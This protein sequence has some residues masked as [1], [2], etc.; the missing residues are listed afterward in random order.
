MLKPLPMLPLALVMSLLW[1]SKDLNLLNSLAVFGHKLHG[2]C[3]D[4]VGSTS[5]WSH[6]YK[7]LSCGSGIYQFKGA[8]LFKQL[9]IIHLFVL[10]GAHIVFAERV[11]YRFSKD[12]RKIFIGLIVLTLVT[13]IKAPAFR[14]LTHW[15]LKNLSIKNELNWSPSLSIAMTGFFCLCLNPTWWLGLS[16]PLSWVATLSFCFYPNSQSKSIV[17]VYLLSLPLLLNLGP[18]SPI[19]ILVN[20]LFS[21]IFFSLLFPL[22]WLSG[23]VPALQYFCDPLWEFSLNLLSSINAPVHFSLTPYKYPDEYRWFYVF[24]IQGLCYF[25]ER[26]T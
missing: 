14:A 4:H 5:P 15:C 23:M 25:K 11:L 16:L 19:S 20:L 7:A 13:G 2:L 9:G 10:S 22:T 24:L 6:I 17:L 8:A 18:A 12:S 3:I 21:P 26:K 1:V